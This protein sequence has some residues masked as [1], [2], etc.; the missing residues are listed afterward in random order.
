MPDLTASER[1]SVNAPLS[2]PSRSR[3][4]QASPVTVVRPI[5]G[6]APLQLRELWEHREL[7][8]F[9]VWRDV[10]VRYKQAALGASWAVIQPFFTMVVFSVFF[11][12]L[13]GLPSDGVP[14]PVFAYCALVPWSYF[15]T[16][17]S[18]ASNSLVDHQRLITKVYFPRLM[19]P[20]ASVI[21]GL[22]DLV[23]AFVVL[24]GMLLFYDIHPT[25]R[26]LALPGFVLLAT[27]TSLGV[28]LWLSA[29][30]VRYRDVR[31]TIPFLVQFWLFLTP[32]AYSSSL[33]PERW[34][35]LYGVNPMAGVVGGF[36]WALLGNTDPPGVMLLVS[37]GAVI[38]ILVGGI[39]YFRRVER[40]FADVV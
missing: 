8:Y 25:P 14:Y 39:F 37:I 19:I 20:A 36:R 13:A 10:K 24:I 26:I 16:S 17:L 12:R 7:L 3:A 34:R 22:V 18:Q 15:A 31:Y 27:L 5:R 1:T 11:G 35:P 40:G 23:I 33:V 2:V 29:F 28:G 9:F 30:N 32:V 21:A 6:W 38:G 4:Q